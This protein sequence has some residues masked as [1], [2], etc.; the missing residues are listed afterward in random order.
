MTRADR[1]RLPAVGRDPAFVFP[2]IVRHVLPNGLHVRTVEHRTVPVV[3][4]VLDVDGGSMA[5]PTGREGLAAVTA[6]MVD[7]GIGDLSL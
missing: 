2:R 3:T 6:D 1:S 7:E 4:I 5:D